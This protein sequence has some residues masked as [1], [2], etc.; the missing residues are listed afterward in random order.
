MANNCSPCNTNCEIIGISC[1]C[2]NCE[3]HST[4]NRCHAKMVSIGPKSAENSH[5]TVCDTFKM[6]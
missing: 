4:D 6:R 5:E 1:K 3:Y 2:E